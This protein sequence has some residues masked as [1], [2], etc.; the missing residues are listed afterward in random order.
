M[1]AVTLDGRP[2][3]LSVRIGGQAIRLGPGP[4]A[5]RVAAAV[6]RA[7]Q[8]ARQDSHE[9]LLAAD[10]ALEPWVRGAIEAAGQVPAGPDQ[11]SPAPG[12]RAAGPDQAGP[13]PAARAAGPEGSLAEL[14]QLR[15]SVPQRQAAARAEAAAQ[16]L[17]GTSRDARVSVSVNGLGEVTGVSFSALALRGSDPARLGDH[18]A[19]AANTAFEKAGQYQRDQRRGGGGAGAPA[20]PRAAGEA[21]VEMFSYRMDGLLGQL[22]E[23]SR[24]LEGISDDIAQGLIRLI[25]ELEDLGVIPPA[26]PADD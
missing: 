15:Q 22:D 12:G 19:E 21:I 13:A 8:A 20:D 17:T 10:P 1:V 6:N 16:V 9:A 25:T 3:V 26:D 18:V 7:L 24:N 11:A 14:R 2:R 23:M 4:L 5:A